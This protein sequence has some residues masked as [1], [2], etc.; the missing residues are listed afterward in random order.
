MLCFCAALP[1]LSQSG[2]RQEPGKGD[3]P[4]PKPIADPDGPGTS[5]HPTKTASDE[6]DPN[7]VVR[8]SSNL[9]RFLFQWSIG[10]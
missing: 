7:D 8:I 10:R 3:K 2:R 4:K 6:V 5:A 1:A 9:V